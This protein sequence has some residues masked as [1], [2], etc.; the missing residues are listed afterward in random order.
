MF[1]HKETTD[2]PKNVKILAKIHQLESR[3]IPFILHIV[4]TYKTHVACGWVCISNR[5]CYI[6]L[7]ADSLWLRLEKS[8]ATFQLLFITT[9]SIRSGISIYIHLKERRTRLKTSSS[10]VKHL[11]SSSFELELS[12]ALFSLKIFFISRRYT[13]TAGRGRHHRIRGFALITRRVPNEYTL[14]RR[15]GVECCCPYS[16]LGVIPGVIT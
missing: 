15:I 13:S 3:E 5:C 6:N 7:V 8:R 16:S 12:I 9:Q 11:T 10:A 14:G 1:H 4:K 2:R